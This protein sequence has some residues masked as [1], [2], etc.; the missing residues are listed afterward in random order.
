MSSVSR[1]V[2][3]GLLALV[4][5]IATWFF[6]L[7]FIE[8]YGELKLEQF[9][10]DNYVNAASASIANDIFVAGLTFVFWVYV[11]SRRIGMR[12]WWVYAILTFGVAIA[13]AFPLY[14]LMRER[15]LDKQE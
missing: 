13:F 12:F 3:F 2:V 4:G 5:L 14:L 10:A 7:Q 1:Q 6:N 11:E 9:I 8:F 15:H